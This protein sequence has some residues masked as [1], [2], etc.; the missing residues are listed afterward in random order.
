MA[1]R[2]KIGVFGAHRGMTMIRVLAKHPHAELVAVC[3]KYTPLLEKVKALAD[4]NG[5]EVARY[6]TFED[7]FRHDMDAVVLANYA[8]EHAPYAIRLLRSG[9]HVMSEVLPAET[10]AQAVELIEAVEE[11]GR[12]Y[13]YA[14]NYCFMPATREMRKLYREG[15]IGEFEYGEGE[16]VHNCATIWPEITYGDRNHWRNYGTHRVLRDH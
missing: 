8:N 16:Y 2:I 10:M 12:V 14:E 7:F 11:S 15:K 5:I 6:E 4:E 3:D 9:R 13:A 1:D